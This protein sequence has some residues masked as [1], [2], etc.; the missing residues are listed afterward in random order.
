MLVISLC[1]G[2]LSA[3]FHLNA[4]GNCKLLGG[5]AYECMHTFVGMLYILSIPMHIDKSILVFIQDHNVAS[6]SVA[7]RFFFTQRER[8]QKG[9]KGKEKQ[10]RALWPPQLA[11]SLA[12]FHSSGVLPLLKLAEVCVCVCVWCVCVSSTHT[13]IHSVNNLL[14]LLGCKGLTLHCFIY[15]YK[16]CLT[17]SDQVN[18]FCGNCL[19][20]DPAKTWLLVLIDPSL[21]VSWF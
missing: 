11:I 1:G 13:H 16:M 15:N 17:S 21:S 10:K 14:R 2:V 19:P 5:H 8:E 6:Y 20:E 18:T 9:K 3:K 12:F 7:T 4:V